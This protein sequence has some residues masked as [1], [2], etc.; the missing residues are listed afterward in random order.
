[1]LAIAVTHG[2]THHFAFLRH[3]V[4]ICQAARALPPS[5]EERF[6]ALTMRTGTRLAAI[7][8]LVLAHHV[9]GEPRCLAIAHGLSPS[10]HARL[11]KILCQ[12]ANLAATSNSWL[13]Y[14]TWRR[15]VF[16]ELLR[17]GA[18]H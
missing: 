8:G 3:V 15:F 17:Y 2:V 18:L 10:P 11:A 5:E 1:M 9:I 13:V 14:N 6:E 4:D 12:G 16:R 7:V